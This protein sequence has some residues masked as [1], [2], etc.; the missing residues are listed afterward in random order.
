[1]RV[2]V[3]GGTGF[4]G[5]RVVPELIGAGHEVLGLAQSDEVANVLT[6]AGADVHEG[7][8]EDLASLESGAKAAEAVVHLAFNNDFVHL[9]EMC[10]VD[11]GAI[12]AL[13]AGLKGTDKPLVISSF[14]GL[15]NLT[16][17]DPAVETNEA[18][19]DDVNPRKAT[20]FAAARLV[21]DGVNAS[22]MRLPMV[23]DPYKQGIITSFVAMARQKGVSA[24]VE[25]GT[26]RF[27]SAPVVDVAQ[28]YRLAVERGTKGARYHAVAEAGVPYRDIAVAIG[29]GLGVPVRSVPFDDAAEQF[30]HLAAF[31]TRD[32]AASSQL[33]RQELGW[34]P[35]G[36][37][38]LEDMAEKLF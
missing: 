10:E 31:A 9:A 26:N 15:G 28:L 25:D 38:L 37:T 27:P 32:L 34:N 36:P 12:A 19:P 33:T 29:S 24:Y 23:H 20:E 8:L 6:R 7:R 11:A 2:F 3:T 18:D 14:V 21:E 35:S 30:E 5:S 17:H 16:A 22:L 4:I 1:M 13:G